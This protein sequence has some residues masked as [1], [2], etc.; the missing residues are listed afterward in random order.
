MSTL[1]ERLDTI[2]SGFEKQAPAAALAVMHRATDDLRTSGIMD[3][4][5][6]EGATLPAFALPDT[7]GNV[8][9]SD[10]LLANGP[11]VVTFYRGKW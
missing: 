8:V 7:D 4:V 10:D 11:L 3:G 1:K 2:R 5:P 9:R 6:K